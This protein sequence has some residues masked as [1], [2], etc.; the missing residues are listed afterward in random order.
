VDNT[1]SP[2]V[3]RRLLAS[4]VLPLS[5]MQRNKPLESRPT[6]KLSFEVETLRVLSAETLDRVDGGAAP[7]PG[8][9]TFTWTKIPD[10]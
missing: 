3:D 4:N 6:K 2:A 1:S 9:M 5:H 8:A 10:L 7:L